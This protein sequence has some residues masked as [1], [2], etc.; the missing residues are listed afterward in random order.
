MKIEVWNIKKITGYEPITTFYEDFSIA[1]KFGA[2]AIK[3]TFN[4]AFKE[5]KHNYKY[6]TELV[7][8]LNW[9]CW[10]WNEEKNQAISKLYYTLFQKAYD[11]AMENLK[12]EEL[13]Y[14][15]RTTD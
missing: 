7:M 2:E 13:T 12:D 11:Y 15:I 5:W 14:F 1:D 9:K 4:R 3:D 8:A 10:R 6:L